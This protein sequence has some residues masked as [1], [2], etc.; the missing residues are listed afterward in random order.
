MISDF[1]CGV[2]R[3]LCGRSGNAY[4]VKL[5]AVVLVLQASL[6][7]S[8]ATAQNIAIA[9]PD[10]P[11]SVLVVPK[12]DIRDQR[13]TKI[14]IVN[15]GSSAS[16]LK[17]NYVCP[18]VKHVNDF[19]AALD[20]TITFTPH[21]TRLVDVASHNPPCK[22]GFVV[23]YAFDPTTGSP[24]DY[25]Q[26]TGSYHLFDGRRHETDRAITVQTYEVEERQPRFM[27]PLN[28]PVLYFGDHYKGFPGLLGGDFRAG[29]GVEPLG[30]VAPRAVEINAG[31][32]ITLVDLNI[33]AGMQNPPANVFIDFWNAS[34]EPFSTSYEFICWGDTR[35][36]QIQSNFLEANLG[37]AYGSFILEPVPNCPLA[38]ACPPLPPHLPL[39]VGA[40]SEY[41]DE[42][43]AIRNLTGVGNTVSF[44]Q[45][46]PR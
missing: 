24:I 26:F 40:I 33:L 46:Q 11:G 15:N 28:A 16:A 5:C 41:G 18:G 34:E 1:R 35:L 44:G 8:S 39:L 3:V 22:Q 43:R 14:Q 23:A 36:D 20:R 2:R 9:N 25:D 19:C 7:L 17:L 32:R 10:L 6:V 13:A 12:F 21:Q 38:G 30:G 27:T 42:T 45:Y 4:F 29:S 37:T 31:T